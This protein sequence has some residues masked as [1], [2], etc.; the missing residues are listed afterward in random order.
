MLLKNPVVD[1]AEGSAERGLLGGRRCHA[2]SGGIIIGSSL[3]CE[4]ARDWDPLHIPLNS[5]AKNKNLC[6]EWGPDR[7]RSGPHLKGKLHLFL[8]DLAVVSGRVPVARRFTAGPRDSVDG[9]LTA[10]GPH[11]KRTLFVGVQD[12]Q[13][14]YDIL[15][16]EHA[17]DV[18]RHGLQ[19]IIHVHDDL[20]RLALKMEWDAIPDA[21][22]FQTLEGLKL[23]CR[24]P[25]KS[26]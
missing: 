2:G 8:S 13:R 21:A 18:G 22:A 9:L 12:P 25:C 24:C 6:S 16:I 5:L 3:A 17:A 19:V 7:R 15:H 20:H 26:S 14:G 10:R 23:R 1:A 11:S 4:S